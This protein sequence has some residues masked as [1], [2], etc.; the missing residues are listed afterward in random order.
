M[1]W[2]K[3]TSV[4]LSLSLS[5]ANQLD[6]FNSSTKSS[7]HLCEELFLR[8]KCQDAWWRY[9]SEN[10]DEWL[11]KRHRKKLCRFKIKKV[12]IY[13][14]S[15]GLPCWLCRWSFCDETFSAAATTQK[16]IF[17]ILNISDTYPQ[18]REKPTCKNYACDPCSQSK[19]LLKQHS[20]H[21]KGLDPNTH[22]SMN[23]QLL[24]HEHAKVKVI[25]LTM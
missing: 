15:P 13:I 11:F 10:G 19:P 22:R 14:A 20:M 18:Q 21:P 12:Y 25:I 2:Y 6:K 16:S 1:H 17:S 4:E 24:H 23:P 3:G 9:Q 5:K 7:S 8:V